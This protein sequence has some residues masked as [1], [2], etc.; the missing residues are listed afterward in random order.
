MLRTDVADSVTVVVVTV[1]PPPVG[2]VSVVVVEP[3]VM[4]TLVWP[5]IVAVGTA[6][7]PASVEPLGCPEPFP[8]ADAD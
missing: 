3:P 1:P 7:V 5:L 4:M 8:P 2:V 6:L